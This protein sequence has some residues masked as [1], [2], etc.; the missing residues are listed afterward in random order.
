VTT[1]TVIDA[2]DDTFVR[3]VVDRSHEVP[4]VVDFWAPWCGPCRVIGP[5]LEQLAQEYVGRVQL[6]KLNTDENPGV[7]SAH[8]IESIPHVIAYRDGQPVDQF[9]GALPEPQVRAFI[10]RLVPS[11]A[12]VLAAEGDR[13]LAAGDAETAERA[14]RAALE[15]DVRHA[16]AIAGLAQLLIDRGDL[17]EAETL[18]RPLERNPLVAVQLGRLEIARIAAGT[19]REELEQRLAADANDVDAHYRLGCLDAAE[20][21]WEEALEHFLTMVM[22]DRSYE[23]DAGRLRALEIIN[24]EDMDPELVREY[25]QRLTNLLF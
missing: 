8:Q 12:D 24:R 14:F 10:E 11:D 6:V 5:V 2:T 17:D 16:A 22:L 23:E 9:L 13:A 19:S 21:R 20:E 7:A 1:A 15:H 3:D 25:R 4:V 18:A